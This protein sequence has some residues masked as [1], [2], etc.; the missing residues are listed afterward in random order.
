MSK[1]GQA[2]LWIQE[3]GLQGN[4]DALKEYIKHLSKIERM[5]QETEIL[6][7][8]IDMFTGKTE[9]EQNPSQFQKRKKL[10][11]IEILNEVKA[12]CKWNTGVDWSEKDP[13]L[14]FEQM[15]KFIEDNLE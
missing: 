3:N 14:E 4:P 8:Q 15:V 10:T 13:T 7:N 5:K 12:M 6:P 11:H 9:M 2:V 1:M